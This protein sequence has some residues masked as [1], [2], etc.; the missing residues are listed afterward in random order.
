[1]RG[2]HA[3]GPINLVFRSDLVFDREI[4]RWYVPLLPASCFVFWRPKFAKALQ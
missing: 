2:E 1:M 3:V 4:A